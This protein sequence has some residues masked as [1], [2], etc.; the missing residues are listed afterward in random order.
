MK[1]KRSKLF[2]KFVESEQ[3]SGIIL[4]LCT[5]ASIIIA[6]SYFGKGYS[7]FWHTKIGCESSSI[8]LKY[9]AEQLD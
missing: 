6:N 9:S 7:D 2:V 1:I 8:A 3:A 4:I 5:G